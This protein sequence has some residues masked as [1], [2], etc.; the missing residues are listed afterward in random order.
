MGSLVVLRDTSKARL[1]FPGVA[2]QEWGTPHHTRT[3]RIIHIL[4]SPS[5]FSLR[6]SSLSTETNGCLDL[7]VNHISC[8]TGWRRSP[9]QCFKI[10]K[11]QIAGK[12]S[13]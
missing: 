1:M 10:D 3:A 12:T 7:E 13:S 4:L 9:L 5:V 11:R 6:V 2:E 8:A